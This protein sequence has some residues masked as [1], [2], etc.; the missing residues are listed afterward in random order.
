MMHMHMGGDPSAICAQTDPELWFPDKG[1]RHATQSA[2]A[3]A[4]RCSTSAAPWRCAT[5]TWSACG[6]A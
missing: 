1:S 3:C 4:A 2:C 5:R 6:A